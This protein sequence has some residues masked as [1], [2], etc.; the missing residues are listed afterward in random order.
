MTIGQTKGITPDAIISAA[1]ELTRR[2][3]LDDWTLRDLAGA[4]GVYPAVIYHHVG[5]RD[6]VDHAVIDLIVAKYQ[7]PEEGLPW[8]AWWRLFLTNLRAVF[9]H[10]PGVAR[11]IA[12]IGPGAKTGSPTVDRAMR[13]LLR[14]GLEQDEAAMV[15]RV[16]II[17]A[18]LFISLE[19]DRRKASAAKAQISDGWGSPPPDPN[20]AGLVTLHESVHERLHDPEKNRDYFGEMFEYAVDRMLDGV[21]MRLDEVTGH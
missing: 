21:A 8:Q 19:D 5:N 17:Q 3:G 1:V 12:L 2:K 20:L 7:L 13:T 6:T 10:Y 18:C 4:L 16:L 11:R 15:C 14:A 9:V